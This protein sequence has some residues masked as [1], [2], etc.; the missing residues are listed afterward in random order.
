MRT[1]FGEPDERTAALNRAVGVAV[2]AAVK[3]WAA[4]PE[5]YEF[6]DVVGD[7]ANFTECFI[8]EGNFD[9]FEVMKALKEHGFTSFLI[10]DHVPAMI[11]DTRWGHRGRAY[12]MGCLTALIDLVNKTQQRI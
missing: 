3:D 7:A 9:K 5:E 10:D 12:A 2:L 1:F 6:R 4:L 11:D 8:N